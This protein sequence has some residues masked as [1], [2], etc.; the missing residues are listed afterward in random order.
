MASFGR[1]GSG[2]FSGEGAR[3]GKSERGFVF[4]ALVWR[5]IEVATESLFRK[6]ACFVLQWQW[7][8]NKSSEPDA[9]KFSGAARVCSW[10]RGST[11]TLCVNAHEERKL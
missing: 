5:G 1:E 10:P 4:R 9:G 7:Q 8:Y 3:D 2:G 6:A 11:Q